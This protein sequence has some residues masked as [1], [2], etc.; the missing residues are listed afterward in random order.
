[1]N[2][3]LLNLLAV[4]SLASAELLQQH[5]LIKK[6]SFTPRASAILTYLFQAL[7]T[8]LL[9]LIT[10]HSRQLFSVINNTITPL[11]LAVTFLSSLSM[12]LYLKSFQVKI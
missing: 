12:V 5:L 11:L 9:L 8:L 7:L 6:E 1:M 2:W 10:L 3:F 4:V